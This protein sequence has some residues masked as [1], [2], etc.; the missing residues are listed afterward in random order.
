MSTNRIMI[1]LAQFLRQKGV[2]IE[3]NVAEITI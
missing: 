2:K 3:Q 1:L